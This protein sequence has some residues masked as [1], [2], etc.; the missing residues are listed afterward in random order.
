MHRTW[1]FIDTHSLLYFLPS[2]LAES[3]YYGVIYQ[4]SAPQCN[5]K[6]KLMNSSSSK[7]YYVL[8]YYAFDS[9]L[10]HFLWVCK[11]NSIK[12][13]E[14]RRW[15][16]IK[17]WVSFISRSLFSV[18]SRGWPMWRSFIDSQVLLL[19]QY[20]VATVKFQVAGVKNS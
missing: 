6:N 5:H 17:A 7:K 4:Y 1:I 3:W 11:C 12:T 20:Q 19:Y 13:L 18:V 16:T 10:D 15:E 2:P 9:W 8:M 14:S